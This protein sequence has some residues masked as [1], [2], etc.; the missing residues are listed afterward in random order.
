MFRAFIKTAENDPS[1]V[2]KQ[3][4]KA[5]LEKDTAFFR[6]VITQEH[7]AI[8][9]LEDALANEWAGKTIR[10]IILHLIAEELYADR[11]IK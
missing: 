7:D 4:Y 6:K 2:S 8:K 1:L 11:W 3:L 5:I 10:I 9:A